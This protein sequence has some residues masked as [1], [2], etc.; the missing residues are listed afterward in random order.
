MGHKIEKE[1]LTLNPHKRNIS[2]VAFIPYHNILVAGGL[3]EILNIWEIPSGELLKQ[4]S[5]FK[6]VIY[7]LIFST[8]SQILTVLDYGSLKIIELANMEITQT[9]EL[10]Q[11][12]S[13]NLTVAPDNKTVA[14]TSDHKIQ[15]LDFINGDMTETIDLKPKGIYGITYSPDGRLLA[16]GAADK[17][18]GI[19]SQE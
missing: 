6:T 19:W 5:G 1:I 10:I 8:N 2:T 11:G 13:H 4:I 16:M 12:Y 9:I 14:I 17:K 3:S 15:I 7:S 18:I